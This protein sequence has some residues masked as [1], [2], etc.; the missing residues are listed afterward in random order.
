[1]VSVLVSSVVDSD[2]G[3]EPWLGQAKDYQIGIC[4]F[5]VKYTALKSHQT[6]VLIHFLATCTCMGI[7]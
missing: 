5:S 4:C 2:C 3:F 7:H 1:M 6:L